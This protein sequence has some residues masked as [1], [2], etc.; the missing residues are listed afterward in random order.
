MV[1]CRVGAAV[2]ERVN[3]DV[4]A[5]VRSLLSHVETAVKPIS[6][7]PA[8]EPLE[9]DFQPISANPAIEPGLMPAYARAATAPNA[10][11]RLPFKLRSMDEVFGMRDAQLQAYLRQMHV[12]VAQG[13]LA[14]KLTTLHYLEGLCVHMQV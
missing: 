2:N 4:L 7:N 10:R 14:A 13:D 11:Y 5:K 12:G 3:T 6:A 1:R 8:I 9:A